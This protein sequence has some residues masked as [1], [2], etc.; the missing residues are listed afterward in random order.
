MNR[1]NRWPMLAAILLVN[2]LVANAAERGPLDERFSVSLGGFFMSSDTNVRADAFE[3]GSR[4]TPINFED[5]FGLEDDRVFRA[6]ATWRMGQQHLLRGMYFQSD[7]S[8]SHVIDENID[9]GDQTF[10]I[11]T[12]VKADLDFDITELAY[13]Y[14]FKEAAD[15]QLGAS[16]GVHNVGF[17]FG[18]STDPNSTSGAGLRLSESV[19]TNAPLPVLGLRGR[20]HLTGDFYAVAHVQLFTLK[21]DNYDGNLQDYEAALVWQFS[22]HVGAGAAYNMFV[23]KIE[24]NRDHFDGALRWRYSGAQLFMRVSF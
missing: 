10:P 11:D 1:R 3:S 8:V 21:F 23:T 17:R 20:W 2:A 7:R 5:T 9:F 18:L 4:G 14:V 22:R 6:D 15:Y 16:I 12:T 13:E 24:A 19:R